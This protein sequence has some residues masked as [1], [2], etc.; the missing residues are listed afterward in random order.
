[1]CSQ[2]VMSLLL[3]RIYKTFWKGLCTRQ[4]IAY[5]KYETGKGKFKNMTFFV[6]RKLGDFGHPQKRCNS[7]FILSYTA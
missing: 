7:L 3:Q 5:R 6:Y 1:M 4:L 2:D